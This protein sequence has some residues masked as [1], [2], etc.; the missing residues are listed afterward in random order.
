MSDLIC[1]GS[2][3][4]SYGV[5]GELRVKS[6]CAQPSDLEKYNPLLTEDGK[7]S[8]ELSLIGL[9]KN[10]FSARILGINS[11]EEADLLRGVSLFA[12]RDSLPP[13]ST[14]EFNYTDL[15]NMEVADIGGSIIGHVR[16]I[17]NH[18]ADDLIEIG[19][20]GSSETALIPFTKLIVP[21]V[22]LAAG[23]IVVDPPE[24]LL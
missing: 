23:R 16:T 19:L 15:I 4:G 8:F 1:V 24:G 9:I 5:K 10:G 17:T 18:G 12:R 11:K 2:I 7:L 21:T 6:F 22:D 14:D 20:K 13:L 3:S